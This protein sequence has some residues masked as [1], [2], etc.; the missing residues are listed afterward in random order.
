MFTCGVF[1]KESFRNC[2]EAV[3]R[4]QP[5]NEHEFLNFQSDLKTLKEKYQYDN[6]LVNGL[7]PSLTV[8]SVSKNIFFKAYTSSNFVNYILYLIVI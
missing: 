4:A 7:N 8:N 2:L 3:I 6:T 1:P 5:E